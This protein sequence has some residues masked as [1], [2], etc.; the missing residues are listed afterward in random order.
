MLSW[1][2]YLCS[3][4]IIVGRMYQKV[5]ALKYRIGLIIFSAWPIYFILIVHTSLPFLNDDFLKTYT[6]VRLIVVDRLVLQIMP[7]ETFLFLNS[8]VFVLFKQFYCRLKLILTHIGVKSNQAEQR[9]LQNQQKSFR[10]TQTT[11]KCLEMHLS[12]FPCFHF[13]VGFK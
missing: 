13:M 5:K 3:L 1:D 12:L 4:K 7:L 10:N 11:Q 8:F 2:F 6:D 9:L